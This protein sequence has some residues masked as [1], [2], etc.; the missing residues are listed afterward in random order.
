MENGEREVWIVWDLENVLGAEEVDPFC[1]ESLEAAERFIVEK[2]GRCEINWFCDE[3]TAT[4]QGRTGEVNVIK[5]TKENLDD[6][7]LKDAQ[8]MIY[9][10]K[11]R[12]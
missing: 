1:F 6:D 12:K 5:V 7:N 9:N 8:A 11:I 4:L 3:Y 10:R 2:Y